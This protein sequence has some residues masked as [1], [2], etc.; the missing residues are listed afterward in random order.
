MLIF[1]G[2]R[3]KKERKEQGW[4]DDERMLYSNCTKIGC[5]ICGE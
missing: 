5:S 1:L 4:D 2:E 3:E